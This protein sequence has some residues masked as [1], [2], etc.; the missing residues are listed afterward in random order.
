MSVKAQRIF[1]L[2][3]T[4]SKVA[5]FL[6]GCLVACPVQAAHPV[7]QPAIPADGFTNEEVELLALTNKERLHKG[8]QPLRMNKILTVAARSHA[9]DMAHHRHLSHTIN[10]RNFIFRI[11]ASGYPV[12]KAGENVARSKRSPDH[13]MKMWMKSRAHRKNILNPH[14]KEIGFGVQAVPGGDKYFAQVFG[15]TKSEWIAHK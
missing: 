8:L 14:F 15:V 3:I 1:H 4:S 2:R 12:A 5:I 10:G 11:K 6:L 13:V 9:V 7:T